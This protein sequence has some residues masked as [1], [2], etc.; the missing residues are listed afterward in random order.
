M[1]KNG[2][3]R[4][5]M[6]WRLNDYYNPG[7]TVAGGLHQMDTTPRLQDHDFTL[8]PQAHFRVRAGYSRN[9]QD[10][11]TLSTS[12]ELD[13]TG[14]RACRCSPNLRQSWNEYR[15][16]ADVEFAGFKFTV[17]RRWDFFKEDTPYYRVGIVTSASVGVPNDPTTLQTFTKA[18]PVH[19]TE[20]GLAG[21]SA[22]EPQALGDERAHELHGRARTIS[23]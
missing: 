9:A 21:Q 8:F 3:Y 2:L 16:G 4:Y 13:N 18:A 6:T 12:L 15:L 10:G 22:G 5:D 19:G 1:Q 7:L 14:Y 20:S 23:R 11:P 17:L